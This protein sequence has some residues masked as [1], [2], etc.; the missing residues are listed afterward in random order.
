MILTGESSVPLFNGLLNIN[1]CIRSKN[2]ES[3]LLK[4]D[5]YKQHITTEYLKCLFVIEY[6]CCLFLYGRWSKVCTLPGHIQVYD[7]PS[8]DYISRRWRLLLGFPTVY[9]EILFWLHEDLGVSPTLGV[10]SWIH[11]FSLA[12]P[13][14][15]G[16]PSVPLSIM[17]PFLLWNS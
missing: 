8:N 6:T 10:L 14:L 16:I 4:P 15:T 1:K 17:F 2:L 11:F 7:I 12:D 3:I 9:W 5:Y 13:A